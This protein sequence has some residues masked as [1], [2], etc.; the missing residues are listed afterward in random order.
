[1]SSNNINSNDLLK[2]LIFIN[3]LFTRNL[4]LN[5]INSFINNNYNLFIPL[6]NSKNSS[7]IVEDA[8]SDF[9]NNQESGNEAVSS[10][11]STNLLTNT[12]NNSVLVRGETFFV[13]RKRCSK[14]RPRKDNIDNIRK[15]IKTR[16]FNHALINKL[17]DKLRSIGS[18]KYF[19]R[20][21][22]NFVSDV[23]QKRNKE[24][25]NMTLKEI[26]EKKELYMHEKG[27]GLLNYAHNLKNVESEEIKENEEFKN[28]LNKTFGELYKEYINSDEFKIDEIKRL[29][30]KNEDE[31]ISRYIYLAENLI[32]YFSK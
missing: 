21:P 8:V 27:K 31:Y 6:I 30:T 18:K 12:E 22:Q 4:Y 17:N 16:F 11:K 26:F 2:E 28:I 19:E 10:S 24:I 13:N 20:F 32:E 5:L 1:M 15:K 14:R 23:H 3:N 29:K 7:P 25:L 9:K